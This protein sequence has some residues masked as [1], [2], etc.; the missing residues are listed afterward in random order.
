VVATPAGFVA[1]GFAR[2][3]SRLEPLVLVSAD[4]RNW[5]RDR[6]ERFDIPGG[7]QGAITAIG[8]HG[9]LVVIAATVRYVDDNR[10]VLVW[11]GRLGPGSMPG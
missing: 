10:R 11:T 9:D 7:V 8:T 3:D 1:A 2:E 5:H 4:G 6:S